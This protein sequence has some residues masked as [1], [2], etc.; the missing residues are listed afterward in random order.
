MDIAP[1]LL[2]PFS[3]LANVLG[4]LLGISAR[5]FFLL[6]FQLVLPRLLPSLALKNIAQ[7]VSA[8]LIINI[9]AF[10]VGVPG[11]AALGLTDDKLLQPLA[12]I[13]IPA[14]I[15]GAS[16]APYLA[17]AVGHSFYA[18]LLIVLGTVCAL[19]SR[20]KLYDSI[21]HQQRH[22]EENN[23]LL[24]NDFE[25]TPLRHE[26]F[27]PPGNFVHAN[28]VSNLHRLDDTDVEDNEESSSLSSVDPPAKSQS[29]LWSGLQHPHDFSFMR[30][31]YSQGSRVF[32]FISMSPSVSLASPRTQSSSSSTYGS[33]VERSPRVPR[34]ESAQ[35]QQA[36]Y[37]LERPVPQ[38]N[39]T[40]HQEFSP[41]QA[42][43]D[44]TILEYQR[45][46]LNFY[47]KF[48]IGAAAVLTGAL[49]CGAGEMVLL[50]LIGIFKVPLAVAAG[51]SMTI[52]FYAV[53][54]AS[55]VQA[56]A[57]AADPEVSLATSVP[58]CLVGWALP[59]TLAGALIGPRLHVYM[60]EQQ[61]LCVASVALIVLALGVLLIDAPRGLVV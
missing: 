56:V 2:L 39:T 4:Q 21:H 31:I 5:P 23:S 32:S 10:S 27:A 40:T 9:S 53:M 50:V 22:G 41:E 12:I 35:S 3:L 58:W 51:V 42:R 47:C 59:G 14:T 8:I 61:T 57:L 18:L 7:G 46:T 60:R 20:E 29:L 16:A 26:N 11:Y 36:A 33:F 17:P 13:A 15:F 30:S 38:S 49:G 34:R 45:P 6:L 43:L 37:P 25:D 44:A 24:A 28:D 1:L 55:M 52:T 54:T 19:R 48:V